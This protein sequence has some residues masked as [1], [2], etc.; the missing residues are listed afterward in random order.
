MHF[1][2]WQS[3]GDS[4]VT[5]AALGNKLT[6]TLHFVCL[7]LYQRTANARRLSTRD[8]SFAAFTLNGGF[9]QNQPLA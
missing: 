1:P 9:R 4:R 6:F 8:A 2:R 5:A 7:A 3:D